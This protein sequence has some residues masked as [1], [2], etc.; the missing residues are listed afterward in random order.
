MA[1]NNWNNKSCTRKSVKRSDTTG[2]TTSGHVTV[3]NRDKNNITTTL[4]VTTKKYF[5]DNIP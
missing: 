5:Q 2:L 1:M 4:E 3:I